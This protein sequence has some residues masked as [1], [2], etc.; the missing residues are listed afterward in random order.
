[1]IS[2][3]VVQI[4][5]EHTLTMAA[6]SSWPSAMKPRRKTCTSNSMKQ[7]RVCHAWPDHPLPQQRLG[8]T[9]SGSCGS[10]TAEARTERGT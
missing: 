9:S 3:L 10:H 4:K 7:R 6:R 1:M 5:D 2:T 8:M